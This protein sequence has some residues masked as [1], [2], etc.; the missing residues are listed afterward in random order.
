MSLSNLVL[1]V[2]VHFYPGEG[3][4]K[5]LLKPNSY[6]LNSIFIT[7]QRPPGGYSTSNKYKQRLL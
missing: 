3:K 2:L 4:K 1:L 6:H 7:E 5:N